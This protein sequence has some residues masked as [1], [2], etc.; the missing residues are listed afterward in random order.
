[1]HK[2]RSQL[3]LTILLAA[4]AAFYTVFIARTSFRVDGRFFFTL[5][6]DAMISMRYAQHLAAGHGLVWNIGEAPIEG[7]TNPGWVLLMALLHT[8]R[9]PQDSISLAVMLI[10]AAILIA[11]AVVVHRICL[12][13]VPTGHVA[14]VLAATITAFYFPLVFWSLRGMEVGLLVLL[15]DLAVL[16]ALQFRPDLPS[17]AVGLGLLLSAALL[18]RLDAIIQA[19][20][21]L[22]YVIA[23]KGSLRQGW[24]CASIVAMTLIAILLLQDAYFGNMLPNTY[25]Q[26]MAGGAIDERLKR[27]VLVF[28]QYALWDVFL[29]IL[30][31]AAGLLRFRELRSPEALL[32]AGLFAAQCL[33]SV[34]V[35]GDYAEPEAA[36]ANRFVAQGVPA[37]II[38]FAIVVERGLAGAVLAKKGPDPAWP[39]GMVIGVATLLLI[40]G[41]QWYRWADENAPLLRSDIR[42]VRAGLAIAAFT[43]PDAVI[44]VHAAGQIPYYS[45]RTTIDLLGLNDAIIARGPR[46][47]SFYP[48]HDKWNYEYSIGQLAPDLIADNWIRLADY[49]GTRPQYRKLENGM[50]VRVDSALV[51]EVGLQEAF[52]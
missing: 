51:E 12:E 37:L 11:N 31:V 52:P 49:I 4:A 17:A 38:L 16:A 45:Q 50:Y 44:A 21:I 41:M 27:G 39:A 42:R 10:S 35:G 1:M 32:L 3:A 47:T 2:D 23:F 48:G 40:S 13:L 25:Y 28:M 6:D 33:Y 34:W 36:S 43:S 15:V 14:P 22:A 30:V 7:F 19:A 24:L 9:V 29:M 5:V 26:K 20:V 46:R 8:F 18:V